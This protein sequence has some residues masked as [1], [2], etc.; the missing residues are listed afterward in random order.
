M[1]A[2]H[3]HGVDFS[4]A[5]NGG[6]HKIRVASWKSTSEVTVERADRSAL[7]R[8]IL[9]SAKGHDHHLWRVDAACGI[10]MSTLR[11][12]GIEANWL[13]AARWSAQSGSPRAWRT[14]LRLI[15]R[16]E[17][18]RVTDAEARTP[19]APMNLR[20]F[21][22]TWTFM[23]EV[24]L[25]LHEAGVSIAPMALADSTATVCEGNSTSVL[26]RLGFPARGYKGE[27]EP[28]ARVRALIARRLEEAGI[29][30]TASLMQQAIAD[31]EGDILDALI[32]LTPPVHSVVP[33]E[34]AVE[35]WVY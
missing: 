31:T 34:G 10:P 19:M 12:H 17:P 30:I 23:C 27:G 11:A 16:E 24:L 6:L 3:I 35:G 15:S 9:S 5:D 26:H 1:S 25:P 22:A 20:C 32:L 2:M 7:M 18:R 14:Q 4:G 13:A 21:K 29:P 28:P 33:V 8:M